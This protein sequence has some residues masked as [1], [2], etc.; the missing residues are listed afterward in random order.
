MKY[1]KTEVAKNI[2]SYRIIVYNSKN[3]T[4]PLK[5]VCLAKYIADIRQVEILGVYA[6]TGLKRLRR[7][8]GGHCIV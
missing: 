5:I 8:K 3:Q 1:C 2:D 6:P 4:R 7:A